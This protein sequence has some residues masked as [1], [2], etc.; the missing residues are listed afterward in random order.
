MRSEFALLAFAMAALVF[1][2]AFEELLP[3]PFGVGFPILLCASI[4]FARRARPTAAFVFV[5]AAGT[6]EDALAGLPFVMSASYFVLAA[7]VVRFLWVPGVF[8]PLFYLGYQFWLWL[9]V[10]DLQGS[11]FM[12]ALLA[13]PVG[14]GTALGV[15]W[16]LDAVQREGGLDER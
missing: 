1:G 9:W 8:A 12:R 14:A 4:W 13:L 11:L 2:G 7:F 16:L 10:V 3:K 5:L 15:T 6:V